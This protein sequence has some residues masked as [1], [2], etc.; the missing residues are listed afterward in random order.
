MLAI[1]MA[2]P[3]QHVDETFD[4]GIKIGV[5]VLKRVANACLRRAMNDYGKA[6]LSEEQ[7]CCRAVCQVEKTSCFTF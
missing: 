3:L 2:A 6:A 4:I 1:V 5:G 7:L